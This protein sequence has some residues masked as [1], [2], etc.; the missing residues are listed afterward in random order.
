MKIKQK[1]KNIEEKEENV[2]KKGVEIENGSGI[3]LYLVNTHE[4]YGLYYIK[5]Q[6]V[7]ESTLK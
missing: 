4:R 2:E 6:N 3:A 1:I 7:F 5:L